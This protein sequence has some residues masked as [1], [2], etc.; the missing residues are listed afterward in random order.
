[1]TI[2]ITEKG[3]SSVPR[4]FAWMVL[5]R[6][7]IMLLVSLFFYRDTKLIGMHVHFIFF[8]STGS[9]WRWICNSIVK[10]LLHCL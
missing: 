7:V 2:F 5:V 4:L 1:L 8:R 10:C 3:T 9:I 6:F